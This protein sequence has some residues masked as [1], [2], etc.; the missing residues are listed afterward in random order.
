MPVDFGRKFASALRRDSS[1]MPS[2]SLGSI[3]ASPPHQLGAPGQIRVLA[4]SEELL[5]K[6]FPV[7]RDVIDHASTVKGRGSGC[8]KD[9]LHLLKLPVVRL[10]S[11]AIQMTQI[12]QEIDSS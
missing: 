2:N 12:R 11:P 10:T 6:K 3:Q 4:I 9:V 8:T 7:Y 5:A 1:H